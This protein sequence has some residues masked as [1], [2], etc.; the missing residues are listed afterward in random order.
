MGPYD[1]GNKEQRMNTA[2]LEKQLRFLKEIDK[3]KNI[4]RQ[5]YL[6][7]EKRKENDAEHS[8]HLALYVLLLSEYANSSQLDICKV[9]KMVLIHD[10]VEIYAGDTFVYDH[11][12]RK[13][14]EKREAD[15]AEKLL[16]MLPEDQQKTFSQLIEEFNGKQSSEALFANAVDRLQPLLHNL[17]TEG[18]SWKEHGVAK[19]QVLS[20]NR[21]MGEGSEELWE[22]VQ[23][24]IEE[25]HRKGWL[26]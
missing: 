7:D 15:A 17:L 25:A 2:R 13:T 19:E 6:L 24:L 10:V 16:S 14:Q 3:V 26:L 22:Y 18:K 21:H 1:T 12:G 20:M 11:E 5:T 4:F 8:W 23:S 9:I